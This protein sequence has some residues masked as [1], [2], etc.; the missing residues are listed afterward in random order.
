MR[1][2]L[3]LLLATAFEWKSS[4]GNGEN[5]DYFID[6]G[7]YAK[8]WYA[9]DPY[10]PT[11]DEVLERLNENMADMTD[12]DEDNSV[13]SAALHIFCSFLLSAFGLA[14]AIAF[15]LGTLYSVKR[16]SLFVRMSQ[17]QSVS[18]GRI[19]SPSPRI[20]E[21]LRERN[22]ELDS[23][24][25]MSDEEERT[26][27]SKMS[28]LSEAEDQTTVQ[29]LATR[30]S[31]ASRASRQPIQRSKVKSPRFYVDILYRCQDS[32]GS[33][34][35]TKSVTILEEDVIE[36]EK[37]AADPG[38]LFIE[39][40]SLPGHP[41]SALPRG[42]VDRSLKP[43]K[44]ALHLLVMLCAIGI[45]A[46]VATFVHL[47]AP[48]LAFAI[49]ITILLIQIPVLSFLLDS[50]FSKILAKEYLERGQV[51]TGRSKDTE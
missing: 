17:H 16:D 38:E 2:G 28:D 45:I 47:S 8:A 30:K 49:Y 44:R 23:Y 37:G 26:L 5:E 10:F 3:I 36:N 51:N 6:D 33:C 1:G 12:G 48:T 21:A 41:M 43:F 31:V 27:E 13:M 42:E 32:S 18:M 9:D 22:Q 29:T 15:T 25:I 40:Y 7:Y 34:T 14:F 35:V 24:S 20:R 11:D 4:Q 46:L 39:L 50:A 19:I